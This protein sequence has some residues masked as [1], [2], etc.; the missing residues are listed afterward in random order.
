MDR[1]VSRIVAAAAVV[2]LA[3]SL[4]SALTSCS[5]AVGPSNQVSDPTKI[6]VQPTGAI[7]YSG[8]PTTLTITGGTGSYLVTSSNQ[9]V[10]QVAGNV[11][12]GAFTFIPNPVLADTDVTLS[13][14]DTGTAPA[15]DTTVTVRPGTV[16]NDI[17]ITPSSTQS[18]ACSPAI[19]SGG[20]A[21][22]TATISQ[23][24]IPLPARSV[25]FQVISGDFR[26]ITTS[27]SAP[28]T[29]TLDT[30]TTVFTDQTGQASA[31]IRVLPG[32]QNQTA[33]LQVTDEGTSAYRRSSFVIAQ[34]TGSSPGFFVTPDSVVFQGPRADQCATTNLSAT[35]FVFGGTPPYRAANTAP[36]AFFLSPDFVACS[37]CN[38]S[39]TPSGACVPAPGVPMIVTDSAGHTVTVTVEN[40][41]GTQAVPALVVGPTDVTLSACTGAGASAS[42]TASGGTGHYFASS[43]SGSVA[44]TVVGTTGTFTISRT[45]PSPAPPASVTVSISDGNTTKDVTVHFIGQAAGPCPAVVANPSTVTLTSCTAVTSTLT[46]GSGSFAV[47]SNNPAVTATVSGST[48]TIARTTGSLSFAPPATVTVTDA[49]NSANAATVTV[50]AT[51]AG[52]G[53]C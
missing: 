10:I 20:D 44:A 31:R 21:L 32:A 17:T 37:G 5:G 4:G 38:F 40:I 3:A 41:P 16:A 11:T 9:A 45:S 29:E 50:N 12:S 1:L 15:V 18:A 52:L 26:F 39:V 28:N 27:P 22:V 36:S 30:Q 34:S 33:L 51:G 25:I 53:G 2:A 24:G 43:G 49:A 7:A 23:G 35:F 13:V 6:T 8:L 46:G 48:L 14:R 42:V 47:A 19:C